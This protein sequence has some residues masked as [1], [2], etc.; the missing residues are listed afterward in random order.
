MHAR[1]GRAGR[2]EKAPRQEGQ[3][4]QAGCKGRANR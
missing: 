2:V 1:Q 3:R 4:K